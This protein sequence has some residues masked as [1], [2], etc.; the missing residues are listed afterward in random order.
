MKETLN[1]CLQKRPGL[2]SPLLDK[3]SQGMDLT[4]TIEVLFSKLI[5]DEEFRLEL[6]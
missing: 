4:N 3:M 1:Y 5:K 2:Q 6:L